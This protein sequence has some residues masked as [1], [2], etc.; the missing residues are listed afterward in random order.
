MHP[1]SDP[2]QPSLYSVKI[3]GIR[4]SGHHPTTNNH[5]FGIGEGKKMKY[6][7]APTPIHPSVCFVKIREARE[8]LPGRDG[9]YRDPNGQLWHGRFYNGTGP[10]SGWFVNFVG[11]FLQSIGMTPQSSNPMGIH[12]CDIITVL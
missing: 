8:P 3:R 5:F 9:V 1:H 4:D 10:G 7:P 12:W 2:I 6:I 11:F